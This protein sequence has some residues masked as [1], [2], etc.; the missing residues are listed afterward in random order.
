M[1]V[2]V[3]GTGRDAA[4]KLYVCHSRSEKSSTRIVPAPARACLSLDTLPRTGY[5]VE[6]R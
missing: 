5:G 4:P 1:T 3:N 2:A 6:A